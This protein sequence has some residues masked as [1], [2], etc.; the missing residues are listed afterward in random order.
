MWIVLLNFNKNKNNSVVLNYD[1]KSENL[2]KWY[3]Q[4]VGEVAWQ[5]IKRYYP[6]YIL[7]AKR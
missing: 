3:Q 5:K 7:Y 6:N 2:F 1:E 4:L